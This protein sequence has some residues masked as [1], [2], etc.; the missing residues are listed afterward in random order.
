MNR[1]AAVEVHHRVDGPDGAPPLLLSNSLGSAL[2]MWEPQADALSDRSRVIRYDHRGHG[3]SPVSPGPYGI[4]DLGADALAL[5]DR[6]GVSDAHVCGLSLGGLVA[7]WIAT[8]APERV[9]TVTL[10]CTTAW[11]GPPDPWLER[12]AIVRA[13]GTDAVADTVVGRW[14][15]PAFAAG[16]PDVIARMRAM[17]ANTPSEGYANC[18]GVVAGTDLRP[19]LGSIRAPTLV[20]AGAQDPAVTPA[21]AA[22]LAAAIP[23]ARLEVIDPAAHLANVERPDVVTGLILE[24]LNRAT[25]EEEP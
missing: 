17:I 7:M 23:G 12:A 19:D 9:R 14:F 3:D 20:I 4:E 6:L 22:D 11:F 24:Q 16:H 2:A 25:P 8:R 5:L 10:C 1:A 18:C 15:T 21:V 13:A